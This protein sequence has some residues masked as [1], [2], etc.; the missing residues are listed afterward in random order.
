[1]DDASRRGIDAAIHRSA[2]IAD[3]FAD[4]FADSFPDR[5]GR[6]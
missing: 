6:V 1:L 2:Q 4:E 5:G 3:E